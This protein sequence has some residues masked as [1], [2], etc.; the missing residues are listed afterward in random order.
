M[1][2]KNPP[3]DERVVYLAL[4]NVFKGQNAEVR[5]SKA[6]RKLIKQHRSQE[7]VADLIREHNVEVVCNAARMLLCDEIFQSTLKAKIRFPELF[8]LS[9]TQSAEREV[10]E[11]EAARHEADAI[12]HA[13]QGR[14]E[15][16]RTTVLQKEQQDGLTQEQPRA[17]AAAKQLCTKLKDPDATAQHSANATP[18]PPLFPVY[19]PFKNQHHLLVHLQQVLEAAC[20]DFGRREMP[21]ILQR[22]GWDCAE[23]VELNRWT[24]EFGKMHIHIPA[25]ERIKKPLDQLFRSVANI[26]HTAVHRIRVS[27]KGTEQFLVDA[28]ALAILLGDVKHVEKMSKMRRETQAA[29]EELQ[30]NKQFL[31]S[32]LEDM[33]KGLAAQR[34]ELKRLEDNAIAELERE[35]KAYEILAGKSVDEVIAPSEASFSTAMET[36]AITTIRSDNADDVDEDGD[37]LVEADGPWDGTTPVANEDSDSLSS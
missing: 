31:R 7:D 19:L 16:S 1:V 37:A 26:R 27:A 18:V 32:R 17:P 9:P 8:D 25:N 3:P 11:A 36:E 13:V 15:N 28:E 22:R 35:D 2:S 33:L 6:I 23:A 5:Q 10:S 30:R 24:E 20:Y 14:S 34:A 4:K 29:M 12:E 21:E